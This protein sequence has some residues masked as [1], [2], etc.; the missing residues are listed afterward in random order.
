M[1]GRQN[2]DIVVCVHICRTTWVKHKPLI[3]RIY[4]ERLLL[5]F[6]SSV[7]NQMEV[8]FTGNVK[9]ENYHLLP[10]FK[11][12]HAFNCYLPNFYTISGYT[13]TLIY[14]NAS[15]KH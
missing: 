2:N 5:F 6:F 11:F 15:M 10:K 3:P 12:Q 14:K 4:K 1:A 7:F 9:F 8:M 13:T